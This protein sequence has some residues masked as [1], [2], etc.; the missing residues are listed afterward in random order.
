MTSEGW[1]TSKGQSD[2][3][4]A[5]AAAKWD[6]EDEWRNATDPSALLQSQRAWARAVVHDF[7]TDGDITC[8]PWT[9]LPL[10]ESVSVT[11]AAVGPSPEQLMTALSA[12][13]TRM[14]RVRADGRELDP[15][16]DDFDEDDEDDDF[17]EDDYDEDGFEADYTANYVSDPERFGD[18]VG[19]SNIDTKGQRLPWMFR[20]YLRIVAEELRNAGAVPA[21]IIP[22]LTPEHS[23]W[24]QGR[25]ERFPSPDQ[26]S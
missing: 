13:T 10:R 5:W 20:S 8:D 24:L 22:F 16:D 19:I 11:L 7:P 9:F 25:G 26:L 14:I 23:A 18:I 3:L 15:D 1:D 17:D 12:A 4:G 6:G 2:P 21:R